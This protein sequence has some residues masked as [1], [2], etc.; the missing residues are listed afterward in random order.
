MQSL[1]AKTLTAKAKTHFQMVHRLTAV[2]FVLVG[3]VQSPSNE[4][5]NPNRDRFV[6]VH[7]TMFGTLQQLLVDF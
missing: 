6:L 3:I 1:A 5:G 7:R 2:L 4:F